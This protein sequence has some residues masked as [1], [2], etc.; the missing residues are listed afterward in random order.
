MNNTVA[1]VR[2]QPRTLSVLMLGTFIAG[3]SLNPSAIA[4][5]NYPNAPDFGPNVFV[6][7]PSTPASQI[8]TTLNNAY[9]Q[10]LTCREVAR[11]ADIPEGTAKSR[12]RLALAKLETVLDRELLEWS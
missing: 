2:V 5:A 12:L 6:F 4:Q 9:F 7:D 8:Q 1:K 3:F 11:A 10:G